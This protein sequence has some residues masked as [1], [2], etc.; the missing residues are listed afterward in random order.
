MKGILPA[1]GTAKEVA[2]FLNVNPRLIYTEVRSGRL[3]AVRVG[4][5]HIRIPREAVE[6]YLRNNSIQETSTAL[7]GRK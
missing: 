5:K 1:N 6:E 2:S 7:G 4:D 3:R